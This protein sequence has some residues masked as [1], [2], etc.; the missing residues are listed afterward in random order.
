MNKKGKRG[1]KMKGFNPFGDKSSSPM[2]DVMEG[3]EPTYREENPYES[4]DVEKAD[5][6][7]DGRVS[8]YEHS[9]YMRSQRGK[10]NPGKRSVSDRKARGSYVDPTR[11]GEEHKFA[12]GLDDFSAKERRMIM[13]GKGIDQGID[14]SLMRGM[15]PGSHE[16]RKH[17][18]R[19]NALHEFHQAMVGGQIVSPET[20]Q[21]YYHQ[22][23]ETLA[24]SYDKRSTS[25]FIG[26][27]SY[28]KYGRSKVEMYDKYKRHKRHAIGVDAKTGR[29]ILPDTSEMSDKE[30]ADLHAYNR[31]KAY[32]DKATSLNDLRAKQEAD[33]EASNKRHKEAK[34]KARKRR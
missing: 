25:N 5:K 27:D 34:R 22:Y 6:N 32:E 28:D 15:D 13:S 19:I 24:R 30:I 3:L 11:M 14:P 10:V 17:V 26:E 16:G 2:K 23:Q 7:E 18:G 29:Y 1:F 21:Q 33:R 20:Y 12:T 8:N 4:Y 9:Q 31:G